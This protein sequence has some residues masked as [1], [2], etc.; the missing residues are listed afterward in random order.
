MVNG[1]TKNH[2]PSKLAIS[3]SLCL[4]SDLT[5]W[6]SPGCPEVSCLRSQVNKTETQY[7]FAMITKAGVQANQVIA[8]LPLYGRSFKMA[9]AGCTGPDC[10]F[11]GPASGAIKGECTDT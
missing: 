10:H 7:A 8:G 1:T 6:P 9:E 3:N 2:P 5:S 11:T 4:S